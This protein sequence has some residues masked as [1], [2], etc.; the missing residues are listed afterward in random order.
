[1]GGPG[2]DRDRQIA[3][4]FDF[5][6]DSSPKRSTPEDGAQVELVLAVNLKRRPGVRRTGFEVDPHCRAEL[7]GVGS[8]SGP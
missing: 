4:L 5:K 8:K 3:L 2:H 1:M 7:V 6:A